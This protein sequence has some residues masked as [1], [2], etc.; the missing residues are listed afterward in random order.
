MIVD[1]ELVKICKGE[2]LETESKIKRRTVR[3]L[4]ANR[5]L[6]I[7]CYNFSSHYEERKHV[8]DFFRTKYGR[9]NLYVRGNK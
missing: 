6:L 8:E 5:G 3:K 2:T 9:E 4:C 1:R 7:F